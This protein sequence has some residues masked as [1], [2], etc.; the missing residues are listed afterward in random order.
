MLCCIDRHCATWLVP[1]EI[2]HRV[3][4]SNGCLK[5]IKWSYIWL[6]GDFL[7]AGSRMD[8]DKKQLAN[9]VIPIR[10]NKGRAAK[11][12]SKSRDIPDGSYR[13]RTNYL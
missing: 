3:S 4:T 5:G 7:D 10:E 13:L 1:L 8:E 11:Q 9:E 6:I 12:R 2:K